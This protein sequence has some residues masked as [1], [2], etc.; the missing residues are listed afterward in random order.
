VNAAD[1]LTRPPAQHETAIFDVFGVGNAA[2]HFDQ[3]LKLAA[4]KIALGELCA[5]ILEH[6]GKR[7]LAQLLRAAVVLPPAYGTYTN[8]RGKL[9]R[10]DW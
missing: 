9:R 2:A 6:M 3:P 1:F 5:R 4:L 7:R 8:V 10:G